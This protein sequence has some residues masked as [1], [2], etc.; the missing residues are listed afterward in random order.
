MSE[1]SHDLISEPFP[2]ILGRMRAIALLVGL[3]SL[4]LCAVGYSTEPAHFFRSWLFAYIFWVGLT[5]GCMTMVMIT[6]MT[7][8]E[9]GVV[10]R[11]FGETAF[12]N[13][14]LMLVCFL[15]LI[16]G[17]KYLFPWAH[18]E[19]YVDNEKVY[20]VLQ[21]R[22]PWLNPTM[23][24]VRNI[25]YMVIFSILAFTLNSGSRKMDR[26]PNPV[27]MRR[28]RMV[29]AIGIV[30]YFILITSFAIDLIMSRETSWYS[31]ILG[32]I[33]AIGQAASGMAFMVLA[34]SFFYNRKPIKDVLKPQHLIDLGNLLLTLVILW[35]Y[36][37][38][39]QLLVIWSG[40]TKEDISYYTYRG[41]GVEP[42]PW[43]WVALFLIVGHF[44]VP[45]FCLLM[46]DLK[47]KVPALAGI[48]GFLLLM[49]VLDALWLTAPSGPNRQIDLSG[50]YWTDIT[51]W[52]GIGGIWMFSYLWRL[53]KKPLLP[54]FADDQPESLA[55]GLHTGHAAG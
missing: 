37:T 19:T 32:F 12:M 18:I 3:V 35:A 34:V 47:Q 45:F 51:A 52:F 23:F 9:W 49:R 15:P 16:A 55:H 24:T 48:A 1:T 8:G 14:P 53:A 39:A 11:R 36:T 6:H 17:Y 41:L 54:R 22:A 21:H 30:M 5:L 42:N 50:V 4:A 25:G 2:P 31:S 46:R 33:V 26:A 43:R 27:L 7:G 44:F 20:A 29:C 28:L 10:I 38:F 40:N 13:M